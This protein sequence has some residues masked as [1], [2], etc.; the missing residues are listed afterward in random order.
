MQP[1]WSHCTDNSLPKLYEHIQEVCKSGMSLCQGHCATTVVVATKQTHIV[2]NSSRHPLDK[3][4]GDIVAAN[5]VV[6]A[7]VVLYFIVCSFCFSCF[8]VTAVLWF[9]FIFVA[10]DGSASAIKNN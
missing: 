7:I 3:D 6:V 4:I 10:C 1:T 8:F 2:I 5:V 9:I